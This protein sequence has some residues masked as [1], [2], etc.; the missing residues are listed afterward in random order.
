MSDAKGIERV[1]AL[2]TG[3]DE[4]SVAGING[5]GFGFAMKYV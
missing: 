4:R 2:T 3:R 1:V 5:E